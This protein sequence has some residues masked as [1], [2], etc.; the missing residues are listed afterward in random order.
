MTTTTAAAGGPD[1]LEALDQR[2]PTGFYWSLTILA[3]IGGFLFGFDT[4]NI[5]SALNFVPYH[6]SGFALGYLV[7]GASLGAAAGAI[8]AGPLTDRLGRKYLLIAD[9]LIY[10]VGALLSAFTPDAAVLL[11]ART[12]IGIAVGADSAIATAYIA[13][14]APRN[15]RGSLGM[16]Q[17]WMVTVGI[18]VAYVVALVI[19]KTMP[20]SAGTLDW[21]LILGLGAVPALIGL[22]LRTRMPESPRWLLRHGRYEEARKAVAILGVQATTEDVERAARRLEASEHG[23]ER[24]K[25]RT[26]T[27]GVRRA[28]MVVC[29][30]FVFQQITG[31]NVPLY[32]GPHLLGP[33]F[34]GSDTSKVAT[35]VAGVEVTAIMTVVNVAATYLAFRYIDRIGRRRL[36]IGGYLGMAVFG[37]VA[38]IGLGLMTGTPRTVVVMIGLCM[39]IASFAVGV[40]GTGWLIQGEVFPTAVRGQAA[41]I[42]AT[43]DWLANFAL[44]E[45]FPTWQS[46][47]GLAWV[48][49]CFA[50]LCLMAVAF[51][52]RFLPETK[53]RS[54]EEITAL[55]DKQAVTGAA[56]A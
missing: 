27:P 12:L 13:E 28:L 52:G 45:A 39:F 4:S 42:G 3:T 21:R 41:A 14:Y 6:L 24:A 19:F 8:L 16:L 1:V 47:I 54:V 37:V 46:A 38:A 5:G 32:Y 20:H 22:V 15:R 30:F 10:A 49:V 56:V 36:A 33:L 44:I 43:V 40:G 7:A 35:T 51:V 55:F 31:I 11:A 17:Q 18:L 48:M 2:S 29:V 9:A 34:Q 50:V 26:W 53:G 23:R 25:F